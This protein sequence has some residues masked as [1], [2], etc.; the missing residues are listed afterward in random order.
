MGKV[1]TVLTAGFTNV[2][3]ILK[4]GGRDID[5]EF[6][7]KDWIDDVVKGGYMQVC[8]GIVCIP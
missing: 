3:D 1:D 5:I 4:E 8:C 6:T 7:T 2:G